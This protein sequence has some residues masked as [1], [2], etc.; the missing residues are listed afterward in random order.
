MNKKVNIGVIGT[1]WWAELVFL[2]V[3]QNYERANLIA[4]CGRNQDR[5][6]EIAE[7]Y[8]ILEVY[9][10]YREMIQ[11]AQLDAIV[12]ATPDDTHYEI[13]IAAL[14]AGLHVLCEKPIANNVDDAREMV[15]KAEAVG[16]KHMVMYTHHWFPNVQ[17]V[18]HLLD[19]DYIGKVYHGYFNWFADYARGGDYMW[20]FDANR[21]NGILGDLG[22]HLIHMAYWLLGDVVAVT[23]RLGF[24]I[25][26]EGYHNSASN[27]AND[28]VHMILEFANGSQVQFLVT[29]SAHVIDHP[30]KVVV[31]LHGQK[32]TIQTKWLP[33]NSPM[34]MVVNAQQNMSDDRINESMT[35]E[36]ADFMNTNPVGVRQFVDSIIDDQPITPGLLEG[37]K[38]QRVID[39]VIQSHESGCRIVIDS[40]N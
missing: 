22:S 37:Y 10:D 13:T 40:A 9:S 34:E 21:A 6:N 31:G 36:F 32:G 30:M 3:L 26:R 14:D 16:V 5:A 18:K 38:V 25:S 19:N 15:I 7:K 23:G 35:V 29:A 4:V 8:K 17:R 24:D 11:H 39:A 28:T 27:P 20:R 12:I 1:S 33:D 2:P